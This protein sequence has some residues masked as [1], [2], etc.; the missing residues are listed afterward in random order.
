MCRIISYNIAN[1]NSKLN[2]GT[3]FSYILK[4]DVFFLFET[5]ITAD[6]RNGFVHYFN[7]YVLYW[8]DAKKAHSA[9]RASGGCLYGFKKNLQKYYSFTFKCIAN[10][11]VLNSKFGSKTV[12]LIPRYI[13]C[14]N[15]IKDFSD[16][17]SFLYNNNISTFCIIGDLNARVGES[18]CIDEELLINTQFTSTRLSKDKTIDSKGKKL[19]ELCENIGGIILNGSSND[20]KMGN[21]TFCGVMGNSMIDY[22]ICSSDLLDSINEFSIA[23][24]PY[25]DHMPLML[26]LSSNIKSNVKCC[27]L[28][29]KLKWVG[30]K[31]QKYCNILN[32][33]PLLELFHSNDN[34]NSKLNS[35]V[36][37][38][39]AGAN[40]IKNKKI[41]E[42]KNKWYDCQC[43]SARSDMFDKLDW[44]RKFNLDT[45][46]TLYIESK[47]RYKSLCLEK[48]NSFMTK[49]I[50]KLNKIHSSKEWWKLANSM[51]NVAP[52]IGNNITIDCFYDHF[53][54][55]FSDNNV[56]NVI[57][58]S[59]PYFT[60]PFLDSP[61][62]LNE[63]F[64]VL[65]NTKNNKSPGL[66]RIPYEFYKNAPVDCLKEL[67]ALFNLIFLKENIPDS[68]RR[69]IIIPLYKKGDANDVSNYRGLSML[70][71]I[72]KIFTG[73]LL[74]RLTEWVNVKGILSEFQAGFRKSYSTID[75]IFSLTSIVKLNLAN[76]KNT[77]AFFCRFFLRF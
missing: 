9:G 35:F 66:D 67:V 53:R 12:T 25:S 36:D 32:S 6:K 42:S 64:C 2:F 21:Y 10:N 29:P 47:N 4:F 20:D 30:S 75:N 1:L 43:E 70:D 58:W 7:D 11:V 39:Y 60:D 62:E 28:P 17:E 19:L 49:E 26:N 59:M 54:H 27:T 51:K 22:C 72:Y 34:I 23:C 55:L 41:F 15:W 24:K 52:K 77:Y 37:K 76:K 3:F 73:I 13:N 46:K 14:T 71:S 31:K 57:Q 48:K 18:Q 61:F 56:S 69:A 44:W 38:I 50:E 5:N 16:F 63:L 74:N 68:F 8:V 65:K 40:S 45:F 33:L